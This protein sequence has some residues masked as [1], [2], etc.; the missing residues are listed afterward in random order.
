MAYK[1]IDMHTHSDNSP[2]G[3]HSAMY[4]CEQAFM[5]GLRGIAITD[6]IEVDLYKEKHFDTAAFQSFIET[7]KAK[8]A[9]MG[10]LLVCTGI[11]LGQPMYD[12]PTAET[13]VNNLPY[14]FVMA[15]VHNLKGMKDF[16]YLDYKNFKID[17]LL[18]RYF[19]EVIKMCEWGKFDSLAHLTYPLR[20]ITGEQKIDVDIKKFYPQI[21]KILKILIQKN[22]ALEINTSGLRQK[23]NDIMPSEDILKMYKALGGEMITFGSDA[24]FAEDLGKGI[25]KGMEKAVHC[26]F[27]HITLF[28]NR[29]PIQIHIEE[30]MKI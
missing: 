29:T 13:I 28:Q 18:T 7:K 16:C 26:G 2:D 3:R 23:L 17:D 21:E 27:E 19:D 24:H 22:I 20:Y 4:M 1:I 5:S 6:H 25:D 12:L 9:F 10:E 15:S 30:E 11:E 14:D 8:Y